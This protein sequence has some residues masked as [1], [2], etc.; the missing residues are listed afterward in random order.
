MRIAM[1]VVAAG[2]GKR[3]GGSVPKAFV[4]LRGQTLLERSIRTLAEVPGVEKIVPVVAADAMEA[5]RALPLQDLAATVA[6]PVAGGRERQDSVAAGV[7]ALG[8]GF[9]LIGVHD[10][11]RCL[12]D[13]DEVERVIARAAET[14]AAILAAPVRDT[15]KTVDGDRIVESPSRAGLWAAQTPQVFRA[16]WLVEALELGRAEGLHGTDDAQLVAHAGHPVFVVEGSERNLKL[17]HPGD[18]AVAEAWLDDAGGDGD[19]AAGPSATADTKAKG[20]A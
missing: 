14:G 11:A 3:F 5:F 16:P 18:I 15:I 4:P 10:A 13:V 7:S 17:T 19:A 8:D 20:A 2:Q 1:V 9:E 6:E 12:V